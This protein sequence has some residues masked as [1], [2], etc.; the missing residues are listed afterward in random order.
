MKLIVVH[1]NDTTKI[2]DR[3]SRF[4][5]AASSRGI[6]LESLNTKKENIY[7]K[8][9]ANPIFAEEKLVIIENSKDL[10]KPDLVWISENFEKLN[11]TLVLRSTS[12]LSK[13]YLSNLPMHT[14]IEEYS[15][16][17]L[18]FK[19]LD[20]FYPGN[21]SE[22][23]KIL[24]ELKI[25]SPLELVF[26]MLSRHIRDLYWAKHDMESMV[27]S[28]WRIRKLSSQASN[29]SANKLKNVIN[30][31]SA[32]DIKV[33]TSNTTLETSI[34]LLILMELE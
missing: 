21:S 1:G 14:V 10:K 29:F 5:E 12:I 27:Y 4:I 34:D 18:L 16:P 19:F 15:L 33:K 28:D 30:R 26:T 11:I 17:S 23:I 24:H 31:V 7:D 32:I 8:L 2:D 22:C 13:T 3:I 9:Q 25:S 20:S 6:V